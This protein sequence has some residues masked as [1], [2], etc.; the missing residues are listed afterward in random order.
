[1]LSYCD[2]RLDHP[3]RFAGTPPPEGND[4]QPL[5][6]FV[7]FVNLAETNQF[8]SGGGVAAGR[9]GK[10]AESLRLSEQ[11]KKS[12]AKIPEAKEASGNLSF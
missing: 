12:A 7:F 8:P 3:T 2:T 11:H 4:L 10:K 6:S 1:M 9:G 5:S